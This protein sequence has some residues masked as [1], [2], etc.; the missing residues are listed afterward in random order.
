[1]E[2]DG[3]SEYFM[4]SWAESMKDIRESHKR[5]YLYF[6]RLLLD[7]PDAIPKVGDTVIV[8][9]GLLNRGH[10]WIRKECTVIQT[11]DVSYKVKCTN[12]PLDD[13]E[14]WVDR[15]LILDVLP[16]EG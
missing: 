4:Q 3:Y 9:A 11:A 2:E 13:W 16:K 8:A 14:E 15:A 7:A 1:M 5:M 6:E 12:P 10:L